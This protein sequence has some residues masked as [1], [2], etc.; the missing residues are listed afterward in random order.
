MYSPFFRTKEDTANLRDR[1]SLLAT[2]MALFFKASSYAA[3]CFNPKTN[4]DIICAPAVTFLIPSRTSLGQDCC[5]RS[6]PSP[7]ISLVLEATSDTIS[8]H[9]FKMESSN[10][11]FL[12]MV[13]PLLVQGCEPND[14]S[15]TTLRFWSQ[16]VIKSVCKDIDTTRTRATGI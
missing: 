5:S 10:S 14:F 16:K 9:I 13:T 1:A 12:A 2:G 15:R 3:C 4:T 8:T 11:F 6:P 7:A